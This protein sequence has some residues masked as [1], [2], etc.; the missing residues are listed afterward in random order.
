RV[1]HRL[2]APREPRRLDASRHRVLLRADVVRFDLF[3]LWAPRRPRITAPCRRHVLAHRPDLGPRVPALYPAAPLLPR[4]PPP[5]AAMAADR[6]DR[7]RCPR[8][9]GRSGRDRLL[10]I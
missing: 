10:A 4:R 8:G 7:R 3:G 6:V 2:P 9:D 5:V 1:A